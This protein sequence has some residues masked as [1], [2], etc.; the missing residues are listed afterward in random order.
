MLCCPTDAIQTAITPLPKTQTEVG[1]AETG[2]GHPNC[3]SCYAEHWTWEATHSKALPGGAHT[4]PST[5][6]PSPHL[7]SDPWPQGRA[8]HKHLQ[9]IYCFSL[10]LST[11][12]GAPQSIF[13]WPKWQMRAVWGKDVLHATG[14]RQPCTG[15][16]A[17]TAQK[18]SVI[19]L[20]LKIVDVTVPSEIQGNA[21]WLVQQCLL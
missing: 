16:H 21:D 14:V 15:V 20:L 19:P 5:P 12:D 2:W 6:M 8:G 9:R 3:A 7:V 11:P 17:C 4:N 10:L 13:Q 1:Q 18:W